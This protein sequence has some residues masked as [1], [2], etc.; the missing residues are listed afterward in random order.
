MGTN[1]LQVHTSRSA[2]IDSIVIY[3]QGR[4]A[5]LV[6]NFGDRASVTCILSLLACYERHS[7]L[8]KQ[9][10]VFQTLIMISG[11]AHLSFL[12]GNSAFDLRGPCGPATPNTLNH[13]VM[14]HIY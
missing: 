5:R 9:H 2:A 7:R 3:V 11:V 14:P 4:T 12:L 8:H 13:R 1:T 10:S 6:A